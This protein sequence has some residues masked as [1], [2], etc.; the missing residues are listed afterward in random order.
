MAGE[1]FNGWMVIG[2][3]LATGAFI[4]QFLRDTPT[5]LSITILVLGLSAVATESI[6]PLAPGH[7]SAEGV[8]T[9]VFEHGS[10]PVAVLDLDAACRALV[11]RTS[12]G[13][14]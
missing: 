5:P 4:P 2:I 1:N 7:P 10:S 12:A 3:V 13:T 6:H 8:V 14:G 11:E 9:G